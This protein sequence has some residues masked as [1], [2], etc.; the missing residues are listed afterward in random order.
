M[1][2]NFDIKSIHELI[3]KYDLSHKNRKQVKCYQRY[4]L[5][6]YLRE[7]GV[8]L[9]EIGKLFNRGHDTVIHGIKV[10]NDLIDTNNKE[11][12]IAVIDIAIELKRLY[13]FN[14]PLLEDIH[15]ALSSN[16]CKKSKEVLH[17]LYKSITGMS[18]KK[19][20]N[21]LKKLINFKQNK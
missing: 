3:D 15:Q 20:Y 17:L 16:D 12:E 1:N 5:Y 2:I 14:N 6:K 19:K 21:D 10:Y 18:H 7:K 4:F 11:F 8:K 9:D 13:L